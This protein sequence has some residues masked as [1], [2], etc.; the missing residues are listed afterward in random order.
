MGYDPECATRYFVSRASVSLWG[1]VCGAGFFCAG[2]KIKNIRIRN[3]VLSPSFPNAGEYLVQKKNGTGAEHPKLRESQCVMSS[4]RF[5]EP[6]VIS[7]KS[8]RSN[9][10]QH[11]I[12]HCGSESSV[13]LKKIPM[14]LPG[15]HAVIIYEGGTSG[16]CGLPV[17][18]GQN[19]NERRR[20]V[21]V[22]LKKKFR[23]R[24][25]LYDWKKIKAVSR[26]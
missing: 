5:K 15:I 22:S 26:S 16:M 2:C 25:S 9:Q 17:L 12:F 3:M 11:S 18:P 21:I 10:N 6:P 24:E 4:P 19:T 14:K 20:V 7:L 1:R 13:L 23:I 8:A